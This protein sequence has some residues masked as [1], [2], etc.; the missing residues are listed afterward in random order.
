MDWFVLNTILTENSREQYKNSQLFNKAAK[1]AKTAPLV[2]KLMMIFSTFT[3]E[4]WQ[5]SVNYD[6]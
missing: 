1:N 4:W 5:T 6:H 2:A 3:N